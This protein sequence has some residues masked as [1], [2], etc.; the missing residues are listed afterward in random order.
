MGGISQA[1]NHG[2]WFRG[3]SLLE[4]GAESHLKLKRIRSRILKTD[5]FDNILMQTFRISVAQIRIQN[6]T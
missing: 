2:T 5:L 4:V 1:M 3:F 6:H